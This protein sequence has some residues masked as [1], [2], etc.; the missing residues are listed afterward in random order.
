MPA[1]PPP[2]LQRSVSPLRLCGKQ[3]GVRNNNM[4]DV[5]VV[6]LP[7]CP[8]AENLAPG[9]AL[10]HLSARTQTTTSLCPRC[11]TRA[12]STNNH[13]LTPMLPHARMRTQ[14]MTSPCSR[15]LYPFCGDAVLTHTSGFLLPLSLGFLPLIC[16]DLLGFGGCLAICRADSTPLTPRATS[17][18]TLSMT[19]NLLFFFLTVVS[20]PRSCCHHAC[21]CGVWSKDP[22]SHDLL[23]S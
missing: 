18:A 15:Y 13:I 14:I 16:F 3:T 11:R 7:H 23:M 12:Q 9:P 4:V 2:I 8:R 5:N 17:V 10:P 6:P 21:R 19:E 20:F 1:L 22:F